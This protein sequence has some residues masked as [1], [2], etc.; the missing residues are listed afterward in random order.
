MPSQGVPNTNEGMIR[1]RALEKQDLIMLH[2]W[3]RDE[4]VLKWY[5]KKVMSLDE[6]G[7][8]YL[9]YIEGKVKTRPFVILYEEKPIG[10]IQTY[11]VTDYPDWNVF[12][13][14]DTNAAG[15]DLFIGES[16]FHGKGIGSEVIREFLLQVIFKDET[17]TS[18]VTGC[19]P[20]NKASIRVFEK[21]GF[22]YWKTI[23][24][25][26]SNEIEYLMRK[27]K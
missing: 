26:T 12:V 18:C 13:G 1:F 20:G 15:L 5:A 23:K 16:A 11:R 3:F 24:N 8:K 2:R 4:R 10:Y 27:Y 25:N 9:P 17:T 14:A 7:R 22:C 6:V 19:N 21:A